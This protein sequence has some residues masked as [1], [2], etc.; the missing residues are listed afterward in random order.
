MVFHGSHC[1]IGKANFEFKDRHF[2]KLS[3]IKVQLYS[4]SFL[5]LT[6]KAKGMKQA[7]VRI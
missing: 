6:I 2:N 5:F 1:C 7:N 4:F 3:S